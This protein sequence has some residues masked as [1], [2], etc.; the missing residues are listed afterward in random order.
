MLPTALLSAIF[1]SY[2]TVEETEA[3]SD[4]SVS[5]WPELHSLSGEAGFPP[6]NRSPQPRNLITLL[7]TLCERVCY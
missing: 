1:N 7:N 5:H 6:G 3:Q 4:E 2:F